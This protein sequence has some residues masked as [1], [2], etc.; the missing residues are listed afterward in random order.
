[1]RKWGIDDAVCNGVL[2]HHQSEEDNTF[3]FLIGVADVIGQILYPF[4]AEA[5]YPL[6]AALEEGAFEQV[7]HFLPEG[8]FNNPFLRVEEFISLARAISPRVQFFTQKM[9]RSVQ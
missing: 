2:N 1:M 6:A 5:E 3:A 4:P 7:R 9:R 8:F